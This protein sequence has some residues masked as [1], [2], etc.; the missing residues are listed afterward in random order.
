[1]TFC[2]EAMVA[3][4][5]NLQCEVCH[6]DGFS[7]KSSLK[8]HQR[9]YCK[10]ASVCADVKQQQQP[11]TTDVKV[12][13]VSEEEVIMSTAEGAEESSSSY[14]V[15]CCHDFQRAFNADQHSC[16]LAPDLDP[17]IP[18]L[19][20]LSRSDAEQFKLDHR[21]N[22]MAQVGEISYTIC[23]TVF[24]SLVYLFIGSICNLGCKN[25][26]LCEGGSTRPLPVAISWACHHRQ[27]QLLRLEA[28]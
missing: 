8:R 26:S 11:L 25:L 7:N 21:G 14:C 27:V 6:L 9:F 16:P 13:A 20:L 12:V 1:M 2:G 18:V 19:R 23:K 22:T 3:S 28:T 10:G 4:K 17:D 24:R 5:G 15:H